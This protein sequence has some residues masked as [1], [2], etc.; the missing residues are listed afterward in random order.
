MFCSRPPTF[1]LQRYTEHPEK[2]E[3]TLPAPN[4][5][6][7]QA[8]VEY[9]LPTTFP[10]SIIVLEHN[11]FWHWIN[12]PLQALHTIVFLLRASKDSDLPT[13]MLCLHA[14]D[15]VGAMVADMQPAHWRGPNDFAQSH[16]L[17]ALNLQRCP[18]TAVTA[19]ASLVLSILIYSFSLGVHGPGTGHLGLTM[20]I[21][22]PIAVRLC[23][24]LSLS[25]SLSSPIS[26]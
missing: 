7:L 17:C 11:K 3:S 15:K 22:L 18:N 12:Q 5:S 13:R 14:F 9:A 20:P 25:P 10:P 23:L 19:C 24:P 21:C 16:G 8:L 6:M 1:K 26:L 2:G 4:S